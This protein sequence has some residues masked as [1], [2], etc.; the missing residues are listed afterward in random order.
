[1]SR[2]YYHRDARRILSL[3]PHP[4]PHSPTP[5]SDFPSPPPVRLHAP[6][7]AHP[8]PAPDA[9][10][11]HSA[12]AAST[13][14]SDSPPCPSDF[15][16]PPAHPPSAFILHSA[17]A[18][19]LL[20]IRAPSAAAA[21]RPP[22]AATGRETEMV[23]RVR[24]RAGEVG[25]GARVE[26]GEGKREEGRVPVQRKGETPRTHELLD[27]HTRPTLAPECKSNLV[28]GYPPT[29]PVRIRILDLDAA[30]NPALRVGAAHAPRLYRCFT[31]DI[32]TPAPVHARAHERKRAHPA[33]LRARRGD[34]RPPSRWR[35][36]RRP[37]PLGLR[38]SHAL[39]SRALV[40]AEQASA[41]NRSP[42]QDPNFPRPKL[43]G[44][45]LRCACRGI[46]FAVKETGT[47]W[48]PLPVYC[49]EADMASRA[50]PP[51]PPPPP[52]AARPR[53]RCVVLA[54]ATERRC[55]I[56][57]P[58]APGFARAIP[59]F[60]GKEG[61]CRRRCQRPLRP[62]PPSPRG[63]RD[64]LRIAFAATLARAPRTESHVALW[65]RVAQP[66]TQREGRYLSAAADR[67]HPAGPSTALLG[68]R[69][70]EY[71]QVPGDVI[72]KGD[73]DRWSKVLEYFMLCVRALSVRPRL[74]SP[75]ALFLLLPPPNSF[76]TAF[77]FLLRVL[78]PSLAD[79]S[80]QPPPAPQDTVPRR[81]AAPPEAAHAE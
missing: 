33:P 73:Q 38:L 47:E 30:D 22:S 37:C 52:P 18:A 57:P 62:P 60:S 15:M 72:G 56:A 8:I 16:L 11:L 51:P 1:M 13:P 68:D 35:R 81:N 49:T 45:A 4:H 41:N 46:F 78:C 12:A 26:D 27:T 9:F 7:G 3:L 29:R 6:S 40:P 17:D 34:A 59:E 14:P 71:R 54:L 70:H 75:S 77:P 50:N 28:F 80:P 58:A 76:Y 39:Q 65:G 69:D 5:P 43:G 64:S 48:D 42:P 36:P 67:R 61:G 23:R 79:T 63:S 21:V 44:S 25:E 66:S 55:G 24:R 10:I 32:A 31:S 19:S 53:R 2:R 74:P 20:P